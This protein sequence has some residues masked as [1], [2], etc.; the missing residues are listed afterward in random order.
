MAPQLVTYHW[1]N[2]FNNVINPPTFTEYHADANIP[3]NATVRRILLNQALFF[4][5]RPSVTIDDQEMYFVTYDVTYGLAV[6]ATYLYRSTRILKE[7]YVVDAAGVTDVYTGFH[8]GGDLELGFNERVSRG[9]W[10]KPAQTVRLAWSIVS[11]G[12]GEETLPGQANVPFKVLYSLP[13]FP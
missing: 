13:A 12:G 9:G 1:V 2:A 5:K 8:S 6:P 10:G 11:S 7:S 4:W 3:E